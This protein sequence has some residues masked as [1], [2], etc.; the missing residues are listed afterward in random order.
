[1]FLLE[2][3]TFQFSGTSEAQKI[4]LLLSHIP[5]IG[6]IVAKRYPNVVTTTGVR[7]SSIFGCIYIIIFTN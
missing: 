2:G 7:L 3:K 1:M 5:F 6:M 4:V